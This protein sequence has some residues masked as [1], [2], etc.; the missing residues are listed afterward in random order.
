MK[1]NGGLT[2][3]QFLLD[4]ARVVAKLV[5]NGKSKAEVAEEVYKNNLFQYPTEKMLKNI[6]NVCYERVLILDNQNLIHHLAYGPYELAKQI[7]FYAIIKK[8]KLI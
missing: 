5:L 8:E 7:N 3:E 1:Y 6:S 4:E 2:R